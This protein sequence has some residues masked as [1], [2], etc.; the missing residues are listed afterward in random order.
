L[1]A[2]NMLDAIE[3]P[4]WYVDG[5]PTPW[6]R[7]RN[8]IEEL[9]RWLPRIEVLKPEIVDIVDARTIRNRL[10]EACPKLAHTFLSDE[11]Y[12]ITNKR[13]IQKFLEL[14][15]TDKNKYVPVWFDCDDF[16]YRLMGQFHRGKWACLAFGIAWS[17]THA[18]NIAVLDEGVFIIEPQTDKLLLLTGKVEWKDYETLLIIM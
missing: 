15:D 7:L 9:L 8:R 6:L 11:E 16:S 1:F 13:S 4:K 18:Y 3:M 12:Q 5:V 10:R 14:D 2:I 17:Q